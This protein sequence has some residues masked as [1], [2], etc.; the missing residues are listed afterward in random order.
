MNLVTLFFVGV[1][2]VLIL[3][4]IATYF[5]FIG[6]MVALVG[7]AVIFGAIVAWDKIKYPNFTQE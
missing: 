5:G 2:G 1:I 4:A 3:K 6:L 7:T